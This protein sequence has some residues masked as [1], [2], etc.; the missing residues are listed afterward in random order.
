[1][2]QI[3]YYVED[4]NKDRKKYINSD[5]Y[6]IS[7]PVKTFQTDEFK[8]QIKRLFDAGKMSAQTTVELVG[9]VDWATEVMRREKE[10]KSGIDYTMYPPII[11]NQEDKG[12]DFPTKKP[13]KKIDKNGDPIPEDKINPNEKEEYN[14]GAKKVLEIAPYLKIKDLPADVKKKLNPTKQ[15]AWMKIW[16]T[17]YK[18]YLKKLKDAKQAEIVA[19]RIAWEKIKQVNSKKEKK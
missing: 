6:I 14:I 15:K 13:V 10:S 16:N 1:M 8:R 18:Y 12:I 4:K 11:Q 2:K 7:S 19:F 17:S 5:T 9:E 3:M